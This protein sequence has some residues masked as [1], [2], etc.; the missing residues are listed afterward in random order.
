MPTHR[1]RLFLSIGALV[2]TT[3]IISG[4]MYVAGL[5]TILQAN[6]GG[7]APSCHALIGDVQLLPQPFD[8]SA[9]PLVITVDD[10]ALEATVVAHVHDGSTTL[11]LIPLEG[12]GAHRS[13]IWAGRNLEQQLVQDGQY[14][15][16]VR[17]EMDVCHDERES[18]VQV[19]RSLVPF[20]E[21]RVGEALRLGARPPTDDGDT[22]IAWASSDEA[23][24]RVE[25]DRTVVGTAP[26]TAFVRPVAIDGTWQMQPLEVHVSR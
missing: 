24:A 19:R 3:A 17:A 7:A 1:P 16:T 15:V 9:G 13:A 22:G 5:G 4:A 25:A 8:P 21:L 6:L 26:G 2:V 12:A 20:V 23:V 11:A 18:T 10:V 14:S